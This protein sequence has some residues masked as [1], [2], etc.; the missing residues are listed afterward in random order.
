[1]LKK[2]PFTSLLSFHL[3]LRHDTQRQYE[4]IKDTR[5][6]FPI[7]GV[8]I[9]DSIFLVS[10]DKFRQIQAETLK[11][12]I[13]Q[14]LFSFL[15]ESRKSDFVK[16]STEFYEMKMMIFQLISAYF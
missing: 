6:Q 4:K 12:L 9:S 11:Q 5:A 16:T 8:L 1:M 13:Y 10:Y 14:D 15:W 2:N 7:V 3:P